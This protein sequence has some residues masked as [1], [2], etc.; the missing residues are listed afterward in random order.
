MTKFVL[1][2]IIQSIPVLFGITIVVYG[3]LLA[4]PGGPTAKFANNPK[5]TEEQKLKFTGMGPGPAHPDA[6]LPL[7]GAVQPGDRGR[8]FGSLPTLAAF[9]GPSGWPNFL[10]TAISG[11]DNGV[12]HGDFGYS[13]TSGQ[14]VSDRIAS[15]ALPTFILA[16]TALIVWLT[17]AIVLGVYAAIHRYWAFDNGA[18]IFSYVGLAMPSFGWAASDLHL[19]G[20]A[21]D[22]AG[23]RHD[24]HEGLAAVRQR[25]VLDV[26]LPAHAARHG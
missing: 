15:A 17:I 13:I 10:P 25:P 19:R 11:A 9:I 26:L 6:V 24:G 5:M 12:L 20:D 16:G 22:P 23:E 21:E 3:I 18:T 2:R 8:L 14:K 4:A 1:R 7:D